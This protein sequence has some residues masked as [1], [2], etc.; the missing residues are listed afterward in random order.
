MAVL[1]EIEPGPAAPPG[2]TMVWH[3]GKQYAVADAS[4]T[5]STYIPMSSFPYNPT[6]SVDLSPI[7]FQINGL[8]QQIG[9]LQ[10]ELGQLKKDFATMHE[11][12]DDLA[13]RLSA[14]TTELQ[15]VL[16]A[17]F[18]DVDRALRLVLDE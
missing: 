18:D 13:E 4:Y 15:R 7:L 8:T 14:W 9:L 17:R 10:T 12:A 16:D 3:N 6:P 5:G 11:W 2:T 1:I